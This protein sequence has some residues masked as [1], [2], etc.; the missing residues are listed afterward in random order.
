MPKRVKPLITNITLSLLSELNSPDRAGHSDCDLCYVL[1]AKG[2]LQ[3]NAIKNMA[4]FDS[5]ATIMKIV[6]IAGI[7]KH[8]Q[9]LKPESLPREASLIRDHGLLPFNFGDFWQFWQCWQ[10][11]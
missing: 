2:S 4:D 11:P 7:A 10:F 1:A 3:R 5:R 8:C 6:N 9:N